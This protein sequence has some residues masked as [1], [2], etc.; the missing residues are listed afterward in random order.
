MTDAVKTAIHHQW[1]TS[2]LYY[3]V[4]SVHYL[5]FCTR[6]KVTEA[7]HRRIPEV[8]GVAAHPK[9]SNSIWW[10]P[11]T[12]GVG[13]CSLKTLCFRDF[14]RFSPPNSDPLPPRCSWIRQLIR[15]ITNWKCPTSKTLLFQFGTSSLII[16]SSANVTSGCAP[17]PYVTR[18]RAHA[19]KK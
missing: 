6:Q 7:I 18:N 19:W 12:P 14:P 11:E 16:S 8:K 17:C 4:F 10:S 13:R 2:F 1:W 15:T 3:L 9:S 5:W